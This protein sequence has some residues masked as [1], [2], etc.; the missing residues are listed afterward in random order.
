MNADTAKLLDAFYGAFARRDAEAMAACYADQVTFEDPVFP[1]LVGEEARDMWRML[2]ESG[3]DL[4]VEHRVLEA[5]AT[6]GAVHWEA[7]YTFSATGRPVHNVIEG[8]FE[9]QDGRIVRHVD[10][11][12][13]HRWARQ[14][15]G[16]PGLLLGWTPVLR[17]QVRKLA[18]KG[19]RR[20]R[21]Q[22]GPAA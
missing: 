2:C 7:W 1:A 10:R 3:K 12:D 21:A 15:L 4:R 18:A 9:V 11:F 5:D 6:S 8:R 17:G 13:F 14:A 22:R 16:L 20:F 19:L